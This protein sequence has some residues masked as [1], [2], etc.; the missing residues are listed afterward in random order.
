METTRIAYLAGLFDGEGCIRINRAMSKKTLATMER[1]TP[2]YDL[3]VHMTNQ[4]LE[5][6]EPFKENWGGYVYANKRDNRKICFQ[7]ILY[8][9]KAEEMIR[10][11]QPYLIIKRE[12]AILALEYQKYYI[13]TKS[14]GKLKPKEV[15]SKL[16]GYY[17][18]FRELNAKGKQWLVSHQQRLSEELQSVKRK[19]K[20]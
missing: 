12:K 19:Y 15:V 6:I 1:A 4:C 20:I 8:G 9:R 13:S 7:W 5:V 10:L 17:W 2:D 3:A 11:L 16:D 14:S 18:K